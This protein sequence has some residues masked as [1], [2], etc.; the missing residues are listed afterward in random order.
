[1]MG[2]PEF[3]GLLKESNAILYKRHAFSSAP[4]GID[5]SADVLKQI[6]EAN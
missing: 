5:S 4:F 3:M 6:L 2:L 1:M